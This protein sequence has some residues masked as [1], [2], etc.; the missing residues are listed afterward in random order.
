MSEICFG[1]SSVVVS[2]GG[3]S[4]LIRFEVHGD[5]VTITS[6]GHE[7]L[8]MHVL[9]VAEMDAVIEW[10]QAQRAGK[11]LREMGAPAPEQGQTT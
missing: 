2:G 7:G 10:Y 4:S 5:M 6:H 1:R 3:N 11:A 9:G 8:E